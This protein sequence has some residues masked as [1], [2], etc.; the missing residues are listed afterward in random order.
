MQFDPPVVLDKYC[1]S[2]TKAISVSTG[3]LVFSWKAKAPFRVRE[4][5]AGHKKLRYLSPDCTFPK[6]QS[7][8]STLLPFNLLL[9]NFLGPLAFRITIYKVL[10]PSGQLFIK[11]WPQGREM[12]KNQEN[13]HALLASICPAVVL[14]KYCCST[15]KA[16][17]VSTSHMVFS[18]R[19]NAPFPVPF[20]PVRAQKSEISR[21]R[22]HFSKN[23]VHFADLGPIQCFATEFSWTSRFQNRNLQGLNSIWAA[24]H[25]DLTTGPRDIQDFVK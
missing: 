8:S 2:T 4:P 9:Q 14:I 25:Q 7:I 11:I 20:A 19:A 24:F 16:I 22:L 23:L 13:A 18:W 17:S 6:N 15:E 21:T 3:H 10:T 1:C 12:K 5:P